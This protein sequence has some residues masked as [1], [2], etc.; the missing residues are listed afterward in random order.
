[1]R[2]AW[3]SRT[4]APPQKIVCEVFGGV[5]LPGRQTPPNMQNWQNMG[6]LCQY[7]LQ[8][9]FVPRAPSSKDATGF[10]PVAQGSRLK[11]QGSRLKAQGSRLKA[12]GSRLKAQ[13]S[14][15]GLRFHTSNFH[16]NCCSLAR[17]QGPELEKLLK[18]LI[19]S[20]PGN[21]QASPRKSDWG[22]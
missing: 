4:F 1:M 3:A 9:H 11:A 15:S 6:R 12:Q 19:K 14:S 2:A 17:I 16:L 5:C 13:G 21:E 8:L 18:N 20:G 10:G 22:G 7:I